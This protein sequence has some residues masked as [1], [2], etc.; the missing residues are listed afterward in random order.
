MIRKKMK[1][2]EARGVVLKRLYDI[3]EAKQPAELSNFNDTGLA[4]RELMRGGA[5]VVEIDTYQPWH[6]YPNYVR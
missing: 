4:P 1:D 5:H 2:Q 6:V 3:R